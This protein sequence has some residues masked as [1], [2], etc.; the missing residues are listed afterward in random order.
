M[1]IVKE[2]FDLLK[3]VP[4]VLN[5]SQSEVK[6][7]S[8]DMG[9]RKIFV[10]L[11]QVKNRINHYTK[12]RIFHIISDTKNREE[13]FHVLTLP[14]YSLPISYNKP[15]GEFVINLSALGIDDIQPDN[16]GVY[17]LYAL[18]V[19]GIVFSDMVSNKVNV[20]DKYSEVISSFILS[21]FMRIFGKIYGL[22][23]SFSSQIPKLEFLINVY[24]LSSFFGVKGIEA[25]KKASTNSSFNYKEIEDKLNSYDLSNINNFIKALS[26]FDI[27]PNINRYVFA[28]KMQR[29]FNINI[30]A[31]LEDC[32]RF[33]AVLT[34]SNIKGS[35]IV[36]TY[37][38]KY[39]EREFA[40]L[41]EVSKSIFKKK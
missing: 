27:M 22:T 28:Q 2:K 32:S 33:F 40:R 30:L 37:L 24:V 11:E 10:N 39:N 29:F 8:V 25:Y 34:T 16:P 26:D 13:Q 12:D 38:S 41:L 23:G 3:N 9:H 31:A 14:N 1:I 6:A 18:M 35:N 15:T 19:Y 36:S 7:N 17:N 20:N 21:L 5:L 4:N